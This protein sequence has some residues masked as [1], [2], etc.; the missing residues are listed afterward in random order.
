MRTN[1]LL[2]VVL[3]ATIVAM[4]AFAGEKIATVTQNGIETWSYTSSALVAQKATPNL[5]FVPADWT[6]SNGQIVE[7]RLPNGSADLPV[8]LHTSFGKKN[9]DGTWAGYDM[10]YCADGVYRLGVPL[11]AGAD[12]YFNLQ[13]DG[14]YLS[15]TDLQVLGGV[16]YNYEAKTQNGYTVKE[17]IGFRH[18]GPGKTAV[19][20]G[21]GQA[22]SNFK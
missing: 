7:I 4:P 11:S 13:V 5:T 17:V 20:I 10:T 14:K 1:F 19:P 3:F 9:S 2:F 22:T 21:G 6:T 16:Y 18:V 15:V 8:T 12:A